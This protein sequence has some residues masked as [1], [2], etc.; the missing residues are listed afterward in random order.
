[1]ISDEHQENVD[2]RKLFENPDLTLTFNKS[3]WY[4]QESSEYRQQFTEKII[5]C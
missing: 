5:G 3:L 1:L 2:I 4:A